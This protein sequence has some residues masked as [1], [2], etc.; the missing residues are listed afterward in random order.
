MC[1]VIG[2]DVLLLTSL[3]D[4]ELEASLRAASLADL[5]LVVASST[6][7]TGAI[8]PSRDPTSEL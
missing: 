1:R 4:K 7:E 6:F 2:G 8:Q 5:T 3:E